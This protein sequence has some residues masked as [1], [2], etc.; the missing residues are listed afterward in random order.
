VPTDRPL[1]LVAMATNNFGN[2]SFSGCQRGAATQDPW[3]TGAPGAV[4]GW[5]QPRRDPT[6]RELRQ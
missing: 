1:T 3:I 4:L 2:M 5:V 6:R